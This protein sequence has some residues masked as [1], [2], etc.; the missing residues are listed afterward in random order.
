MASSAAG[1]VW[2]DPGDSIMIQVSMDLVDRLGEQPSR[3]VWAPVLV[4]LRLAA[5]CSERHCRALDGRS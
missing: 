5:C 4:A 2:E 3:R 1:F